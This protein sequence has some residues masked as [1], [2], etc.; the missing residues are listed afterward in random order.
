MH[1]GYGPTETTIL[2]HVSRPDASGRAGHHRRPGPRHSR[3]RSSTRGCARCRSACPASCTSP[4]PALARGYHRRPALTADR[5]VANPFGEPGAGCTAPATSCAGRRD[6]TLEYLGRS[7]FQV[8]IRGFRIEL[9]EID[10]VLARHPTVD[11]RGD[12]RSRRTVRATRLLVSY[13][14]P[15]RRRRSW[16]RRTCCAFARPDR[17]PRTWCPPRSSSST[18]SR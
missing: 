3:C 16:R 7:D 5:F 17:C 6:H 2:R 4:G 10:A 8:K 1:N 18:R 13:V 12:P 9:G 14:L 15:A 11:V